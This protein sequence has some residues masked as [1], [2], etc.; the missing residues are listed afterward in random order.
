MIEWVAISYGALDLRNTPFAEAGDLAITPTIPGEPVL[1]SGD[2]AALWR[3]L[4]GGLPDDALTDDQRA[5]AREFQAH[6]I[7]SRERGHPHRM[8]SIPAPWLSSPLHELVY[9]LLANVSAEAN[10]DLVFI[11]G[12]AQHAQGLRE[13]EHSGDVDVWVRRVDR[14]RLADAMVPWGWTPIVGIFTDTPVTHSQTLNPGPWGCAI[15]VHTR[16]PGMTVRDDEAF[17]LVRGT[18]T[19]WNYAGVT[20]QV[21]DTATHAVIRALHDLRPQPGHTPSETDRHQAATAIRVAGPRVIDVARRLGAH[22]V[23]GPLLLQTYPSAVIERDPAVPK[24]WHAASASNRAEGHRRALAMFPWWKRPVLAW[25]LAWPP[26]D[27]AF[28]YAAARG[29]QPSHAVT[30][31]LYRLR[32]GISALRRGA[33][34]KVGYRAITTARRSRAEDSAAS[35]TSNVL[36]P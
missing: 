12:P 16:F 7:A 11:K 23:L 13:R 10:I 21:P 17:E 27:V 35:T 25:R 1:L 5:L 32:E 36:R 31:R 20:G 3:A 29:R 14:G 28:A 6:G 26:P 8:T 18:A 30:A 34:G 15:D 33:R 22:F 19:K 9:G 24:D 4:T 2:V